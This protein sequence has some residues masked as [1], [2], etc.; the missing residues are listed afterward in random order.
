MEILMAATTPPATIDYIPYSTQLIDSDDINAVAKV[1]Q[2]DYL[3]T[4]P[5]IPEFE[6]AMSRYA[7]TQYAVAV[8]NGTAA[9]HLAC[10]ALEL[11]PGE[12]LWTSPN[13]FVASA[14]CGLYCGAQVDFVDIDSKTYNICMTALQTKL[15]HAKRTNKLPKI[16]VVVHFAGQS[17]DMQTL[18]QLS[19]TYGFKVI[20]DASHALGG[21]Y[22]GK[23]IGNCQYSD[24]TVFSLHPVKSI[25]TGEGGLL[26]SNQKILIDKLRLLR[27]HGITRDPDLLDKDQD[28]PWYYEQ[29]I[30]GFNYRI[31]DIQ[32]ALGLSQLSRLDTFISKRN[33]VAKR[34]QQLLAKLPLILPHITPGNYSAYHLFPIQI[35]ASKTKVTRKE[36]FLFLRQ[37][38]IGVN[39]HY[40]PIHLEPYYKRLGFKA[41]DFPNAEQYYQQ[42]ISLPIYPSL[43]EA[44]QDYV[45]EKLAEKFLTSY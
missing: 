24:I 1:L 31:T 3:T 6:E 41:G 36:L 16:I 9:L 7:G 23:K 15:E 44:Q 19:T 4:G 14:N 13:S 34:Y 11:Q 32:C 39:V 17:C 25:T 29:Q 28:C 5:I 20:E 43:S 26:V 22:Q 27:T 37:N 8:A 35:D 45:Y 38:K 33:Q 18:K 42:T 30:L 10:L 21:T 40:I 12:Y 2:S